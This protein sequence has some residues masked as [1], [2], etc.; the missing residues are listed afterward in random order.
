MPTMAS[1]SAKLSPLE[2][3]YGSV[4]N[5][6]SSLA[7]YSYSS[8][9]QTAATSLSHHHAR[10]WKRPRI[11]I[12]IVLVTVGV[13]CSVFFFSQHQ[14][15]PTES[16]TSHHAPD[17]SDDK[18]LSQLHV[19]GT[20]TQYMDDSKII[21]RCGGGYW[22]PLP[23]PA[24]LPF[25]TDV[26]RS[27][28]EKENDI[29]EISL[30]ET[31]R[32]YQVD[33]RWCNL[34]L[35]AEEGFATMNDPERYHKLPCAYEFYDHDGRMYTPGGQQMPVELNAQ[36]SSKL[37]TRF[38]SRTIPITGCGSQYKLRFCDDEGNPDLA[39]VHALTERSYNCLEYPVVND[40]QIGSED[41]YGIDYL[42]KEQAQGCGEF[43]R[44][45]CGEDG[46]FD[47]NALEQPTFQY[48]ECRYFRIHFQ[49]YLFNKEDNHGTN[50]GCL[51]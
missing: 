39:M 29:S 42:C 9:R 14:P 45:W 48:D 50:L 3:A 1:P 44:H 18:E 47:D 25:A 32:C 49:Y 13:I 15:T 34:G 33:V 51:P 38:A 24:Y 36:C 20:S 35:S 2:T 6:A 37:E 46:K 28:C 43:L 41:D 11:G 10:N 19:N 16:T 40:Y 26:D 5:T 7:S 17:S 21:N 31:L 30:S 23:D 22:G 8:R 4:D 27:L 12:T